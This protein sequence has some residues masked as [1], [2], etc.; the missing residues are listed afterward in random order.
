[1]RRLAVMVARRGG[2]RECVCTCQPPLT[3][4]PLD[5]RARHTRARTAVSTTTDK[6]GVIGPQ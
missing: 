4:A 3:G 1:V 6:R 2:G 5:T